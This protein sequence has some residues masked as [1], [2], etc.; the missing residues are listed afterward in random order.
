M[1]V[2]VTQEHINAANAWLASRGSAG[3]RVENCPLARAL[4]SAGYPNGCVFARTWATHLNARTEQPIELR[5]IL[6]RQ[7]WDS[8]IHVSPAEFEF[9]DV[10]P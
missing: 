4:R 5:A 1:K 6:F 9:E 2:R 10:T 3:V 8:G 7:N